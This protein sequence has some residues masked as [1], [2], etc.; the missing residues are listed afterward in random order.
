MVYTNDLVVV[1][2]SINTIKQLLAEDDKYKV[3]GFD[4]EY[5]VCRAE[6]DQMVVITQLCVCH[7]VLVYHYC[8]ATRPCERFARV[9]GSE[10]KK[11]KGYLV[12]LAAAI[13]NSYY[14]DM[15]VEY[16]KDKS[17]WHKA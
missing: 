10:K 15:K 11:Q 13:I 17:I 2:N 16:D 5:T 1:E 6:Y 7:H 3:V 12:D 14:K 8:M 4:L 9:W